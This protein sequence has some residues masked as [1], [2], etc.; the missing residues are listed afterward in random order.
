MQI[1]LPNNSLEGIR[2]S[3]FPAHFKDTVSSR[4]NSS[5]EILLLKHTEGVTDYFLW[6]SNYDKLYW[7]NRI[8]EYFCHFRVMNQIDF[9][10][11]VF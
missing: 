2:H 8:A 7:S 4:I 6:R 9:K 11:F 5:N 1:E 10:V 3:T